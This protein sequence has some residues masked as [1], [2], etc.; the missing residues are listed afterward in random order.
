M[1][2]MLHTADNGSMNTRTPD[3][4]ICVRKNESYVPLA[5]D[6]TATMSKFC[7]KYVKFVYQLRNEGIKDVETLYFFY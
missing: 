1:S 7:D 4:V 2:L 6:L 5:S 3:F